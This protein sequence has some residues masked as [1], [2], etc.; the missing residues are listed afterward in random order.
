MSPV[1]TLLSEIESEQ[2]V[3]L[4]P[5][6]IPKGKVTL[7][8]GDPGEGKSAM[9]TD[10]AARVS[11]GRTLPDGTLCEAAGVVLLSAEDGVAD[12]I[13]PRVEAAGGNP[14]RVLALQTVGEGDA[15][16]LPTLPDDL[17]LLQQAIERVEAVLVVIDPLMAYL[18]PK[19]NSHRDQDMRRALAPL[20]RLAQET[21][22]AV[23]VIRHLNKTQ[24]GN[25]LYRGGGSIGIIGAARS[26]LLVAKDPEDEERRVLAALKCNL[27]KLP[28]SLAFRLEEA[29]NGA[30]RVRWCGESPL[31]ADRLLAEPVSE[32]RRNELAELGNTL[33]GLLED[34]GGSWEG[35]PRELRDAL[36]ERGDADI[37]DRPDEL[38]KRVLEVGRV[39]S[40]LKASRGW[41]KRD[42]KSRR[43][44]RLHQLETIDG[45][46]G[47]DGVDPPDN[48]VYTDNADKV[49]SDSVEP[50]G[51]LPETES[52]W[53]DRSEPP[54]A[55]P[56]RAASPPHQ[57]DR[58]DIDPRLLEALR[59]R[60]TRNPL[61]LKKHPE[62]LALDLYHMGD[63]DYQPLVGEVMV[64]VDRLK[65]GM[66]E[67]SEM[68]GKRAS[69]KT[70]SGS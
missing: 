45:V 32:E 23:V 36:V 2:V 49:P 9:M 66:R 6:R 30:V 26:G 18:S 51:G 4:W 62:N 38:S 63:L 69:G 20:A 19:L 11:A 8:D 5:E 46:A 54:A 59:E 50:P 25:P 42:G 34:S 1:G 53:P 31:N 27:T 40:R 67:Q 24:G 33:V 10:L 22:T 39:S 44:L 21:R 15:E 64:A 60:A 65:A 41:R 35:E 57:E 52:A 56:G 29:D 12:T 61:A 14:S 3:W 37:S 17:P 13:L 70:L 7:V 43:I 58:E 48:T 16:R 68:D 47:V 55:P 28:A